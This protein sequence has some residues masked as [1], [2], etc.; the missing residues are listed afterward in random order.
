MLTDTPIDIGSLITSDPAFRGGRP[1]IAGTGM[2]VREVAAR[3]RAGETAE[4]ISDIPRS[5][6]HAAIAYYL[7]NRAQ[8][9]AEL[10]EEAALY[11]QLAKD[12]PRTVPPR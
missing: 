4:E 1:C 5:H 11:E 3:Y 12:H 9:G 8:I 7:A 6:V 2:S 10:D